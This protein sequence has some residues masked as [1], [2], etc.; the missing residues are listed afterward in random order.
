VRRCMSDHTRKWNKPSATPGSKTATPSEH[1]ATPNRKFIS[2][3]AE[4]KRI[5]ALLRTTPKLT[6]VTVGGET[7]GNPTIDSNTKPTQSQ[8]LDS[9]PSW[10]LWLLAITFFIVFVT[11]TVYIVYDLAIHHG[12]HDSRHL[13]DSHSSHTKVQGQDS[14][15]Q[16]SPDDGAHF[17]VAL[18]KSEQKIQNRILVKV[19]RYN[20]IWDHYRPNST[21]LSPK[22]VYN[23]YEMTEELVSHP[24]DQCEPIFSS[25]EISCCCFAEKIDRMLCHNDEPIKMSS[26]DHRDIKIFQVMCDLLH[27]KSTKSRRSATP[28]GA[29]YDRGPSIYLG[30]S[31][32]Y[33]NQTMPQFSDGLEADNN[34]ECTLKMNF[35]CISSLV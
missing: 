31:Y 26:T 35:M 8:N 11:F 12:I 32:D 14:K 21:Q 16:L 33:V 10:L 27:G 34:N 13:M 24:H 23:I 22:L 19:L 5:A 29:G 18:K 28:K 20:E 25:I 30:L 2:T 6:S 9:T 3:T 1:I 15:V 17:G 4:R 7:E